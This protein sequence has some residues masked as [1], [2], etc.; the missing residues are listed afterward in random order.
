[1]MNWLA[2]V[3]HIA[4]KDVLQL[5][6]LL[7]VQVLATG[8]A[9]AA[10]VSPSFHLGEPIFTSTDSGVVLPMAI[11]FLGILISVLVVQT[12]SPS[13]SD[14]FWASRPLHPL[15]VLTAKGATLGVFLLGLPLAAQAVVLWQHAVPPAEMLPMLGASL[16]FAGG[17][18]VGA[19]A[20][21]ALTADLSAFTVN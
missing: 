14:A 4:K 19:A 17:L 8:M 18:V 6:W 12:D 3:W 2:Q 9:L 7:G 10:A 11:L 20:L 5:R 13:R 21:A 1:M 16:I 15:A